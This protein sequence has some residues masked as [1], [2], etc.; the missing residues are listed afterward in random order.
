MGKSYQ[1]T[2]VNVGRY[3]KERV[4][5]TTEMTKIT[6]IEDL[7]VNVYEHDVT[8]NTVMFDGKFTLIQL[9]GLTIVYWCPKYSSKVDIKNKMSICDHCS[10][11]SA[12]DQC[13]SK[14]EVRCTVMNTDTKVK[15]NVVVPHNILKEIVPVSL[16]EKIMFIKLLLKGTFKLNT[17][18]NAILT[19]SRTKERLYHQMDLK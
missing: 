6:S 18:S 3:K 17:Q 9:G 19:F 14:C 2:N 8:P 15:Y 1:F 13:S 11:V 10:T 4:L 12:E 7:Y 5:K 16:E